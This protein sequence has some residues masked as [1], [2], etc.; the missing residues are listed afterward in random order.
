[1]ACTGVPGLIATPRSTGRGCAAASAVSSCSVRCRCLVASACTVTT[2]A[3]AATMSGSSR[4]GSSTSR[5]AST[6]IPADA[7]AATKA[8]PT[9]SCGQ[10]VPS[11]TSTC[12]QHGVPRRMPSSAPSL[13]RSAVSTPALS[14]GPAAPWAAPVTTTPGPAALLVTGPPREPARPAAWPGR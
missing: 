13:V 7:T 3:P 10:N 6:G 5:C 2:D 12:A 8:G 14:L 11:I 9:V 4:R 1:M